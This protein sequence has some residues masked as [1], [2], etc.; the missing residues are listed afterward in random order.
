[1]CVHVNIV[2]I[3]III[4][5]N[6]KVC[7]REKTIISVS[8][9]LS[10]FLNSIS[11]CG[12]RMAKSNIW[13]QNRTCSR[14]LC[15]LSLVIVMDSSFFMVSMVT[16]NKHCDFFFFKSDTDMEGLPAIP[17]YGWLPSISATADYVALYK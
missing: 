7:L 8:Q 15:C 9:A 14:K 4:Y 11:I 5:V 2:I 1:M 6:I 13:R 3:Y 16:S 17:M 12:T 10:F